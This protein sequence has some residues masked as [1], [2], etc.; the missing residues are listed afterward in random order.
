MSLLEVHKQKFPD[1]PG[2]WEVPGQW[3]LP[4]LIKYTVHVLCHVIL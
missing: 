2:Q 3:E 1:F 4:T